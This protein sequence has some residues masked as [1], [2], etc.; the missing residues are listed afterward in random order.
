MRKHDHVEWYTTG[1]GGTFIIA[2]PCAGDITEEEWEIYHSE[3][4]AKLQRI[5]QSL[6]LVLR[7]K[8]P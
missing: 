8:R 4:D 5:A 7:E 3:R 6:G 1:S 2:T